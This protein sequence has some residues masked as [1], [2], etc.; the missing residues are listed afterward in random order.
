MEVSN[1]LLQIRITTGRL[2]ADLKLKSPSFIEVLTEG[3][4]SSYTI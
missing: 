3:L 4:A 1:N 2:T